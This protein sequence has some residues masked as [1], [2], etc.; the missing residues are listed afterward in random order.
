MK[1]RGF[2]QG[3][4][5]LWV[6]I[7]LL[8]FLGCVGA[9]ADAAVAPHTSGMHVLFVA[10]DGLTVDA[11]ETPPD[12]ETRAPH[13]DAFA[14]QAMRFTRCY[15]QVPEPNA[16]RLSILT[17]LRPDQTLSTQEASANDGQPLPEFLSR[18]GI[19]V[20]NSAEPSP[21][22]EAL[23]DQGSQFFTWVDYSIRGGTT[24]T[25][26][27]AYNDE[28][29]SLDKRVGDLLDALDRAGL[30]DRTIVFVFSTHG[31][32]LGEPNN[33]GTQSL[34][35]QSTH[36]P[37]LIRVPGLT[38][39]AMVCDEIVELVDLFP[40]LC[41]LLLIPLPNEL[42]GMSLTPLLVDPQRPWKLAAFT[43]CTT[44]DAVGQ[45]VRTKRWRYVDWQSRETAFRRF[46]LYDLNR[47]PAEQTNL[48]FDRAYR[49][50]RTILANLLQRG[51]PVA[52]QER[53]RGT[54]V[55]PPAYP[56]QHILW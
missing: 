51:W 20:I 53:T 49:N 55:T 45:S 26:G 38:S 4:P 23:A 52:Q 17:G 30:C 40:T 13:L 15:C 34:C 37:L 28:V 25:A 43:T 11:L 6:G 5:A 16:S 9:A 46:E 50:P 2:L 12:A 44:D 36:V 48:A 24:D 29:T 7:A 14:A 1:W 18:N 27:D 56:A 21:D 3:V 8:G 22:F 32:L 10:V 35:E 54:A 33:R 19:H 31:V 42:E 39:H 47:D 41:D